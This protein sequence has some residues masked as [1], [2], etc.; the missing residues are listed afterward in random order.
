MMALFRLLP[1]AWQIGI[2]LAVAGV[3]AGGYLAWRS[4]IYNQ[5]AAGERA[6]QK[7]RDDEIVGEADG[8]R[9]AVRRCWD[10][11][12]VWDQSRGVCRAR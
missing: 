5:G 11:G 1:I 12:R 7:E 3:V 9:S 10:A 8:A 6:Q 4:S 2:A